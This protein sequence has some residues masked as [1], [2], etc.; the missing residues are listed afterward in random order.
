MTLA[1]TGQAFTADCKTEHWGHATGF[2]S[3]SWNSS[4]W[5]GKVNITF[6]YSGKHKKTVNNHGQFDDPTTCQRVVWSDKTAWCKG[7]KIGDK[8]CGNPPPKPTPPPPTPPPTPPTP[9][10]PPTPPCSFNGAW[11]G[12]FIRDKFP[13]NKD[14]YNM[15]QDGL[16][17]TVD[18]TDEDWKHADCKLSST[19][20]TPEWDGLLTVT[21]QAGAHANQQ[22]VGVV[23]NPKNCTKIYLDNKSVWCK[24]E[25]DHFKPGGHDCGQN[26]GPDPDKI[27]KVYVVFSNHLDVGYTDN[28][29]GSCA[30]AVVNRYWHDHIPKAIDTAKQFR[31]KTGNKTAYRW[32]VHA[33]IIAMY[34]HCSSP[35]NIVN[36]DGPGYP[37]QL[38]CPNATQLA[39]LEAAV[40]RGDITWHAFPF[41]AEP[42]T[43][44]SD[45]FDRALDL[46][47]AEDDYYGHPHRLTYNQRDVPGL[48]RAAI[49]KLVARGVKAVSVGENG[50]CAAVNVPPIFVWRDNNTQT[51]VL[52]MFHP[53]GYGAE[54]P[55]PSAASAAESRRRRLHA[56][57]DDDDDDLKAFEEDTPSLGTGLGD[58]VKVPEA[59]TALC[60]AW[61]SDNRGP[62][63]YDQANGV[64]Q[65]VQKLFPGA[66]VVASDAFDDFVQDVWE[67]RDSLPVVTAEIGD[68]WIHGASTDPFRIA[69][70]R[71]ASRLAATADAE[72][73]AAGTANAKSDNRLT[74]ER[75]LMKVGEH[76]WGWNGG[77][78]RKSSWSNPDLQKS[79][80]SSKDF[81]TAP[82]TWLEQRHF[83]ENAVV[84]LNGSSIDGMGGDG[85]DGGEGSARGVASATATADP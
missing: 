63:S 60:Y 33:W 3:D 83:V 50:Q 84:A 13:P 22:L 26:S 49:P 58:C 2:L 80:K 54:P 40:K 44:S 4:S 14:V 35:G 82:Y 19:Y 34:R 29:N 5:D 77:S 76:T 59:H 10:P 81:I 79:M 25:G 8:D 85:G 74:F 18:T 24:T 65:Q 17:F 68:T 27:S 12:G 6:H 64:F 70:F 73:K 15:K 53:H 67:H 56:D 69:R 38:H 45:G 9:P 21:L 47:F 57:D 72:A 43:Y 37:N 41:N 75:L 32:M 1:Q 71:A 30:G 28:N 42:E 61:L 52:A 23:D 7:L 48:T 78:I 51:E 46:T 39:E 66:K 62:H 11:T 36:I 20:G 16:T 55:A 31:E